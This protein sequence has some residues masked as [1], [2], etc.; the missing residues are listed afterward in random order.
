MRLPVVGTEEDSV[1]VLL[2][3]AGMRATV[4]RRDARREGAFMPTFETV[5]AA[6]SIEQREMPV[7]EM[8][9][10]MEFS[11]ER[12]ESAATTG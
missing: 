12:S 8:P 6:G 4:A 11:G 7:P 9:N 5:S 3:P 1:G 2:Q 10:D